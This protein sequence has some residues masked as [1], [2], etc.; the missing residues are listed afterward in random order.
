MAKAQKK[1]TEPRT[2]HLAEPPARAVEPQLETIQLN[3]SQKTALQALA[4]D[5]QRCLKEQQ[6]L[7]ARHQQM[8]KMIEATQARR[9]EIVAE[10]ETQHSVTPG[11]LATDWQ[12][13]GEA[14]FRPKE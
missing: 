7:A 6:E 10:I 9:L 2:L 13:N 3:A 4:N 1:Q 11:S 14:F 5:D 12:F 8:Q